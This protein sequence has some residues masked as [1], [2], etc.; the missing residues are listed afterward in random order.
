MNMVAPPYVSVYV[1]SDCTYNWMSYNT[2]HMKMVA[3]PYVC[4]Y[5]LSDCSYNWMSYYTIHMNVDAY[6]CVYQRN[7]C[8]QQFVLE[9]VHSEYPVKKKNLNISIYSDSSNN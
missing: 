8:I 1:L 3:P 5:V 9:D 6:P 2:L 4:V 7:I